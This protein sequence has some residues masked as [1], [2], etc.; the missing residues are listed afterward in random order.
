MWNIWA[1]YLNRSVKKKLNYTIQ[2]F[3]H[4]NTEKKKKKKHSNVLQTKVNWTASWKK[5]LDDSATKT[6]TDSCHFHWSLYIKSGYDETRKS[7]YSNMSCQPSSLP[8]ED[9]SH[10]KQAHLNR[11]LW[12]CSNPLN[13][14]TTRETNAPSNLYST[15][16]ARPSDGKKQW[17]SGWMGGGGG[18]WYTCRALKEMTAPVTRQRALRHAG[19]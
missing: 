16:L 5:G 12:C 9:Y 1:R 3:V 17:V 13:R 7:E 8:G 11:N 6:P 4:G 14:Q 2:Y 18:H 19:I 15:C 10:A